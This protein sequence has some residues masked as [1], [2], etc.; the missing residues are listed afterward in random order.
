MNEKRG[1]F[2]KTI[3]REER[4]GHH[5]GWTERMK[6]KARKVAMSLYLLTNKSLRPQ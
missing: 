3:F 2:W 1:Q 4:T 5:L 6:E